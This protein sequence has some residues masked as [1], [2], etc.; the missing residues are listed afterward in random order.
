M[1]REDI[2][3]LAVQFA[4][5]GFTEEH[6][7]VYDGWVLT[8]E[9][10]DKQAFTEMVDLCSDISLASAVHQFGEVK[11]CPK[12]KLKLLDKIGH[13]NGA[14][15]EAEN[16]VKLVRG[17]EQ[18]WINLPIKGGGAKLLELSARKSDGFAVSMIEIK[19]GSVFP[20]H[21]HHGVEMAYILEGD[22]EADDVLLN[23]GDFFRADSGTHHGEHTSPSGCRALIITANEN[24]KHKTVKTLGAVQKTYRK[25]KGIFEASK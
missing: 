21:E 23:A 18:E 4:T 3:D 16:R 10:D 20:E 5:E 22:L 15:P 12:V 2:E 25:I 1:K 11:A 17:D 19:P 9:D 24:Y 7:M 13:S 14:I 6:Q 8:A